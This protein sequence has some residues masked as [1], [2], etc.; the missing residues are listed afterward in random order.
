MRRLLRLR[1]ALRRSAPPCPPGASAVTVG[2]SDQQARHVHEPALRAAEAQGRARYITPYDV[3]EEPGRRTAGST[4]GSTAPRADAPDDPD[5]LRAL[6]PRQRTRPRRRPS[7]P[8]PRSSRSSRRP[9]RPS[10]SSISPW[11]EVNRCQ[12]PADGSSRASRRKSARPKLVAQYYMAA[13]KV[14]TGR[15]DRRDRRPRRHQR[16]A[17]TIT[18]PQVVPA[19]RQADAQ[20]HRL[21]QLLRHQPLLA[22]RAPSACW[23][24]PSGKVW[25]TETGGIVKLGTAFRRR[26]ELARAKAL[27]CMFTMA[28]SNSRIKRLYV[29]QFNGA[30]RAADDFD[31]GPD[32]PRRAP[33]ARA[34]R[35]SRSARRR[36][37]QVARFRDPRG[38]PPSAGH[39]PPRGH[40]PHSAR[41]RRVETPAARAAPGGAPPGALVAAARRRPRRAERRGGLTVR[42]MARAADD[43]YEH[44]LLP[45]PAHLGRRRHG[46]PTSW[47]SPPRGSASSQRD[48]PGLYAEVARAR[49]REEAAWL[50][51]LDRLPLAARGRGPVGRHQR[52]ARVP[53]ASGE[54]PDLEGVALGPRT[55][56]DPRRGAPRSW[57]TAPGPQRAGSQVAALHRRAVVDAAAPLRPRLRAP[58]AARAS[59]ARPR[60]ELLVV[61]GHC[62]VFDVRATLAAPGRRGARPDGAWRPSACF[63]IG[64]PVLLDPQP[65]SARSAPIPGTNRY[66]PPRVVTNG[67][68]GPR[69]NGGSPSTVILPVPCG[70]R[71]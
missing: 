40:L 26:H 56:H 41:A 36:L 15:T 57:P 9:I 27:G 5:L 33:S 29:Y 19:L 24:P 17:A 59:A 22:P 47:P 34:T 49:D 7:R 54:V 37:P 12:A 66:A 21:P 52:A 64:D 43:G 13:R 63:G 16:Q 61:L 2:V 71:P 38:C 58:G 6:P 31:A 67:P 14:F 39:R 3:L 70:V 46:W 42:R 20:G 35:S 28:K 1:L 68:C 18:L 55:A 65:A 60:Y 62:R 23:R 53:W 4:P 51:F 69:K 50:A 8:T 11:N 44:D 10:S 25:L 48:P 45:G 32:Q 30:D